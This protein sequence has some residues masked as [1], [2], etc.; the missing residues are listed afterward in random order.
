MPNHVSQR[1]CI[2]G[3]LEVVQHFRRCH[4]INE[5]EEN[6]L[7]AIEDTTDR[8]ER[9]RSVWER[10]QKG[11]LIDNLVEQRMYQKMIDAGGF[12]NLD[13]FK[14]LEEEK[15][16][17]VHVQSGGLGMFFSLLTFAGPPVM[18]AKGMLSPEQERASNR[19]WYAH[20]MS[21][22]GTKWDAYSCEIISDV[23]V[24]EDGAAQLTFTFQTAWSTPQPIYELIAKCYPEL[25]VSFEY[26][27]EG[28]CFWGFGLS[29]GGR[30]KFEYFES[31]E[32]EASAKCLTWLLKELHGYT[33]DDLR[34]SVEGMGWVAKNGVDPDAFIKQVLA[35][36]PQLEF[37]ES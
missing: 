23:A 20:N 10:G 28:W 4:F 25:L 7:E 36:R 6:C 18:I 26:I 22:I 35:D 34:E 27:D 30:S 13:L 2:S 12:E 33:D 31:L 19:N 21:R 11:E 29:T 9:H 3:P 32:S 15:N 16:Q 37:G 5:S 24:R 8:I 1:I 14:Q 17:L